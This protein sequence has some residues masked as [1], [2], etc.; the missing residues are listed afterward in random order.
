MERQ[1]ELGAPSQVERG[2]LVH[3]LAGQE[4]RAWVQ[5]PSVSSAKQNFPTASTRIWGG[6]RRVSAPPD[7]AQVAGNPLREEDCVTPFV[8]SK[9][10]HPRVSRGGGASGREPSSSRG[11]ASLIIIIIL[12][13]LPNYS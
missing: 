4:E 11:M 9:P 8:F 1:V 6:Q 12:L 10:P 7:P 2:Q 3:E 5:S 13:L